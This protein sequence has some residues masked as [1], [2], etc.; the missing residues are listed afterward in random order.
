MYPTAV[1]HRPLLRAKVGVQFLAQ[2]AAVAENGTSI[3][4]NP[5]FIKNE[6]QLLLLQQRTQLNAEIGGL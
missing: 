4:P 3:L 6:K 2:Q 5:P 1:K